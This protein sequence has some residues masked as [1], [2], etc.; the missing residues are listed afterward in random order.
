[1]VSIV[2]EKVKQRKTFYKVFSALFFPLHIH[3][4]NFVTF[5]KLNW[6]L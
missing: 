3:L 2:V 5:S 1:M 4:F 6:K